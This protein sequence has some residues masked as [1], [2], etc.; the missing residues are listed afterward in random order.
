MYFIVLL[1]N[2]VSLNPQNSKMLC[3]TLCA[4]LRC[5]WAVHDLLL[6]KMGKHTQVPSW[7]LEFIPFVDSSKISKSNQQKTI[8]W[9]IPEI[10]LSVIRVCILP[11]HHGNSVN[12]H[13]AQN[14]KKF[15][16]WALYYVSHQDP[17]FRGL[18]WTIS[19]LLGTKYLIH[20]ALICLLLIDFLT[21]A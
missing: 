21:K 16:M 5:R 17:C 2:W 14:T 19:L 11:W 18:S 8:C 7:L 9:F 4:P 3:G 15:Y 6:S 10:S 20:L 1:E 12:I 13:F